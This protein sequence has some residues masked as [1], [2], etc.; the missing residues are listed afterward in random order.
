MKRLTRHLSLLLM[1][2]YMMM[3]YPMYAQDDDPHALIHVVQRGESLSQIA[4]SYGLSTGQLSS[5]NNLTNPSN[6]W[7]GQRLVIPTDSDGLGLL[8][9]QSIHQ[10]RPGETLRSIANRYGTTI[11]ALQQLNS[12]TNPNVIYVGQ[13][14]KIYADSQ[15]VIVSDTIPN[16]Q[17]TLTHIVQRG[18]TLFGIATTYGVPMADIQQVNKITNPSRIYTGQQLIIVGATDQIISDGRELPEIIQEI[19]LNPLVLAEGQTS[20]VILQTSVPATIE[21]HFLDRTI[22]FFAQEDGTKHIGFLP[23]P[24]FTEPN[25]YAFNLTINQGEQVE[26]MTLNIQVT[27]GTYG[28]QRIFLPE[29]RTNLLGAGVEE[30]EEQIMR[31]VVTRVTPE[32]Y[33]GNSMSLPAASAM[34]APFGAKRSY[35]GGEYDRYHRGADFA[36]PTGAPVLATAPGRVVLADTLHI[37]GVALV[38]DHGWGVYTAYCHMSE[39]LVNLG[40]T[41]R[42]GQTIGLVGNSGRATGAHLHWELWVNGVA[43]DP[44]QWTRTRFQ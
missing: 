32:R 18:E 8:T 35:N 4:Q 22:P 21:G 34:N 37:C 40:D 30:N 23:V 9:V 12:I 15:E 13:Q 33:F 27:L 6:I 3:G 19:S 41:V 16:D 26:N 10:V 1:L 14:I 43:V 44:L 38:I 42:A 11:E 29:D 31:S 39:R 17:P 24:I 20:Q 25:I 5:V 2:C 7:V 28:T 36:S